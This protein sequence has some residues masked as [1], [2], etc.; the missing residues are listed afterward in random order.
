[1]CMAEYR[2]ERIEGPEALA[3]DPSMGCFQAVPYLGV[4]K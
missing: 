2:H 1:M 4:Q 3:S